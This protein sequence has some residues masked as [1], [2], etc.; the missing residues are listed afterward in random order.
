MV[1]K[2][3][4]VIPPKY[5]IGRINLSNKELLQDTNGL[6]SNL[7]WD[8]DDRPETAFEKFVQSVFEEAKHSLN[9]KLE[10]LFDYYLQMVWQI[11]LSIPL[12]YVEGHLF[13]KSLSNW[14]EWFEIANSPKGSAKPISHDKKSTVRAKLE[15]RE[16]AQENSFD[17]VF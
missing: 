5:N 6:L 14:A 9:P 17:G 13:D 2:K 3:Q 10:T 7:P 15:L 4:P 8:I 12:N 1:R 11:S 16:G